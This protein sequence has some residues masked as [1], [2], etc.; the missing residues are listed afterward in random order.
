MITVKTFQ[1]N[2][3]QEN[4][5]LLYDESKAC[6]I[7]DCGCLFDNEKQKLKNFIQQYELKP[8]RLLNTHLHIDHILGNRFAYEQY[9]LKLEAHRSDEFL[10]QQMRVQAQMFGI[11]MQADEEPMPIGNYLNEGDNVAFGNSE[12]EILHVPGHSPGSLVFY[13]KSDNLLFTGDV[14]FEESIGRTDLPGGNYGDL[15]HGIQQ[16]L[17]V[18]PPETIVL[19]GHGD[20]STIEHEKKYN[21]Y[22]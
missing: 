10:L 7:I 13:S 2:P 20:S 15:I 8:T 3:F 17:F 5:Y 21:P 12:L 11:P 4:T 19:P 18:L 14:L 22:L 16:K 9:G 6:A 1:F